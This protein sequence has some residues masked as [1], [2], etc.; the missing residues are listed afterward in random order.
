[1]AH[2][3]LGRCPVCGEGLEVARLH[4]PSCDTSI[5]GRFA[6]ARFYQLS[7]EQIAFLELFVRCEGKLTK[8]Q[9]ELGIS[10]PTAR[11]RLDDLVRAMGYEVQEDTT[12]SLEQRQI[13]LE[14]LASG[15][16]S[17]ADAIKLLSLK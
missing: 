16:I 5:E 12:P 9:D 3:V 2:T 14:Q 6:L 15:K 11:N 17:S 4:C 13:I 1:M 8:V 7:A 10:Y